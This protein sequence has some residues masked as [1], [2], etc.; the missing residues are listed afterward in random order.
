MKESDDR[1]PQLS[2][3]KTVLALLKDGTVTRA[4]QSLGMSQSAL[5]YQLDRMR[6]RFSDP[7][8][9]R[10]GNR[11]APT[12]F[13]QRLAEPA[14][15][16]VHIV[17]TEIA[18][19]AAFDPSTTERDF[20]IGLNELGAITLLPKL[21]R[22]MS[23]LAPRAR[24]TPVTVDAAAIPSALDS[25]E[26]D[27]AAGHFPQTH[28][29]LLQ[30]LLYERDYICVV[31]RDHPDIGASM[32]MREF[33]ETPCIETPASP[34]TRAWLDEEL[35]RRG[36]QTK[37]QMSVWHVS[38]IPFVVAAC[39]CVA[40]IP[41]EVFDIFAPIAAIRT[42]KLPIDIPPI[43]IHQYW[44]PRVGSDPAVR[45][46]REL[47]FATARSDGKGQPEKR[48]GAGRSGKN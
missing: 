14:A 8:F 7:L 44:H 33:S 9:V 42:V 22:R 48:A 12:P 27:I 36:L 19:L 39:D 40:V 45:F 30:Q 5:S 6:W 11:M 15:R 37:V 35:G 24:L 46:F 10:V 20:R 4:A 3:L 41:R 13:A 1:E 31:R 32:T 26:M 25:G 28:D 2:D 21:V 29:L 23:E 34:V 38:A 47:V 17:D 43:Q 16:V 18:G